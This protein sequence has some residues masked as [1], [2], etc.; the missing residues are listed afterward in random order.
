MSAPSSPPL[1]Q[2]GSLARW[3]GKPQAQPPTP[4][5]KMVGDLDS[6]PS[7]PLTNCR[8]PPSAGLSALV[9]PS[10]KWEQVSHFCRKELLGEQPGRPPRGSAPAPRV[11]WRAAAGG[12]RSPAP[13]PLLPR[14]RGTGG[15]PE[16]GPAPLARRL[17]PGSARP[18]LLPR[19]APAHFAQTGPPVPPRARPRGHGPRRRP[20]DPLPHGSRTREGA[21]R[22]PI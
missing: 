9:F 4:E 11:S 17:L 15:S 3:D 16:G 20:A 19:A 21:A 8:F 10:V 13:G 5:Q 2:A 18:P 1:R 12:G 7:L 6:N 14:G 22:A